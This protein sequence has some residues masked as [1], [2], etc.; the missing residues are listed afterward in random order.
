LPYHVRSEGPNLRFA[1]RSSWTVDVEE[2]D[3]HLDA[4]E[5]DDRH[6]ESANALPGYLDALDW[7]RGPFLVD[8]E[9]GVAR[10][11]ERERLR[12][13]YV[14]ALVRAGGLLLGA[15]S[16]D[17]AQRLAVAAQ[18]ADPWSDEALCLQAECFLALGDRASAL[19]TLH[20]VEAL[21]EELGLPQSAEHQRISRALNAGL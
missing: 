20:R 15:G 18:E 19:R 2:F 5:R 17:H 10:D 13:R 12:S 21:T 4:A 16:A 9:M 6:G 14:R 8:V 11:L 1:G 7:Y 3:R